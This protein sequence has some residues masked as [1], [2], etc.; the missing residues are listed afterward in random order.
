MATKTSYSH[1]RQNLASLWDEVEGS[2][3]AAIIQ[4][5]GHEDMALI[6]ADELASLRETA[7]LLRSPANAERLL[8]A[9]NRARR[10]R[11]KP[12]D[13]AA[14]RRELGAAA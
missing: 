3:V 6:P 14:L 8:A 11:T 5:R 13:L 7:Y 1:A 12:I 4:R 10:G 9:L 2:R